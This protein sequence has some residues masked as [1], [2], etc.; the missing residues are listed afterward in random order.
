MADYEVRRRETVVREEPV[1]EE[2]VIQ[3]E[4]RLRAQRQVVEDP[5][6]P[7]RILVG[8]ISALIWLLFGILEALIALRVVLKLIAANP[9]TGFAQSLY[10]FTDV[11]LAPFA[12]LVASPVLGNGVLEIYSIIAMVVYLLLAWVI[13]RLFQLI[14][15]PART[16]HSVTTYRKEY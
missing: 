12:G 4:P 11:F 6:A 16:R 1:I 10:N 13:I 9:G 8:R 2:T 15:T 7:G 3:R 5:S 14:F